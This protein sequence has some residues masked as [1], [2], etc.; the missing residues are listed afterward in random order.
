MFIG[1][2]DRAVSNLVVGLFVCFLIKTFNDVSK[3]YSSVLITK[4]MITALDTSV[5]L[6]FNQP[7]HTRGVTIKS[8]VLI[9][10]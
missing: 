6:I 1:S 10:I 5:F 8:P 7:T 3:I 9:T 2:G 4:I